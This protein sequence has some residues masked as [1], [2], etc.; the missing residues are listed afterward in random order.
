MQCSRAKFN[1]IS[2]QNRNLAQIHLSS[3]QITNYLRRKLKTSLTNW[4]VLRKKSKPSRRTSKPKCKQWRL[5][6]GSRT[7]SLML[8][9]TMLTKPRICLL[10]SFSVLSSL[11]IRRCMLKGSRK[12]ITGLLVYPI[13]GTVHMMP[14][15]STNSYFRAVER[16]KNSQS[17]LNK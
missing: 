7:H 4:V 1:S 17:L 5:E 9:A 16:S 3:W 11:L 8:S 13:D 15:I 10:R 12:T 14:A 6:S 2:R